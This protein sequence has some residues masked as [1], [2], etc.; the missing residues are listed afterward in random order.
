MPRD[1]NR[2]VYP[3]E[4]WTNSL[5]AEY[6]GPDQFGNGEVYDAQLKRT[7]LEGAPLIRLIY[8]QRDEEI[9]VRCL[10]CEQ[11]SQAA[12]RFTAYPMIGI[13][14]INATALL[15][16]MNTPRIM[17][18]LADRHDEALGGI[19]DVDFFNCLLDSCGL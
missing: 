3:P 18:H 5:A 6:I 10:R 13:V 15:V 1:S 17:R 7:P 4:G 8:D 14:S 9:T 16:P 12:G 19:D 2:V 11:Q